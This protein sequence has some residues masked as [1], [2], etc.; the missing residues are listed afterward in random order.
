MK[1]LLSG[2]LHKYFDESLDFRARIFNTLGSIGIIIG[3]AI[4][5]FSAV[6]RAG[7]VNIAVNFAVSV[8]A[9]ALLLYANSGKPGREKRFRR[10]FMITVAAVFIVAFPVLFFSAGGYNSGMPS[11]FAFAVTFTV[12]ML[13]GKRRFMMAAL[14]I[15][16]Y[17]AVCLIAYYH[18]ET[19]T[20][21]PTAQHAARDVIGGFLASSAALA[22]AVNLHI[23]VYDKRQEQLER[24][25]RTKTEFLGNVSHELVTPLT[26]ISDFAQYSSLIL[27][28]KTPDVEELRDNMRGIVMEAERTDRLVSQLLDVAAIESGAM[29]I[30]RKPLSLSDTAA[31]VRDLHFPALNDKNNRLAVSVPTSLPQA[32]AD[33]DRLLQV[34]INLV[35]NACRHTENG[36]IEISACADGEL[37]TVCVSDDGEGIPAE[38][39]AKLF[40]RYLQ[41][42]AGL[43]TRTGLGLYIC[44][45]I[46]EAH[47]GGI[48]VKSAVGKGTSVTFTLPVSAGR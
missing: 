46:I 17:F 30:K 5:V 32:D 12:F 33:G 27:N 16:L 18:P 39:Q 7:A 25:N 11:F 44:N 41:A 29:A 34:L 35:S 28:N 40:E 31:I 2:F 45:K 37:L 36:L 6:N 8:I 22:V 24:L 48:A 19:V 1:K 21:F 47:G 9:L 42:G 10:C 15:A 14:E 43:A 3:A 26:V 4:G 13:E 20:A 38:I 23:T